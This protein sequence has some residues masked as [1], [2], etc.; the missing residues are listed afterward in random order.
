MN[1]KFKKSMISLGAITAVVAPVAAVVS[2]GETSSEVDDRSIIRLIQGMA[3]SSGKNYVSYKGVRFDSNFAAT[4]ELY[5][6]V[7]GTIVQR[8]KLRVGTREIPKKLGMA[9]DEAGLR[10]HL[11]RLVHE[12]MNEKDTII[13]TRGVK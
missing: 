12:A 1:N 8:K 11:M 9:W 10:A 7:A 2:C 4:L 13:H 6:G 5:Y 3:H